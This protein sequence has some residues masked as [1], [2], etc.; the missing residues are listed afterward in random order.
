MSKTRFQDLPVKNVFNNAT[1]A[2]IADT[3]MTLRKAVGVTKS[4]SLFRDAL[5]SSGTNMEEFT[6]FISSTIEMI[7]DDI[8]WGRSKYGATYRYHERDGP[9]VVLTPD[10]VSISFPKES[11]ELRLE[12]ETDEISFRCDS[13]APIKVNFCKSMLKTVMSWL[14]SSHGFHG[15]PSTVTLEFPNG[16]TTIA[17][18]AHHAALKNLVKE[19]Q[20]EGFF[21]KVVEI[22]IYQDDND[23]EPLRQEY[24]RMESNSG[25]SNGNSSNGN[26]NGE[27]NGNARKRILGEYEERLRAP[28]KTSQAI[29]A[30]LP[31]S[32]PKPEGKNVSKLIMDRASQLQSQVKSKT[33]SK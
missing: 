8:L 10:D 19:L 2:R 11:I 17:Q 12:L 1:R 30:F 16:L 15:P 23:P 9:T 32:G 27:S 29:R 7:K 13:V 24:I 4:K 18:D 26:S 5:A 3:S 33:K 22:A 28:F 31:S 20:I 25:E 14:K 21:P 6:A